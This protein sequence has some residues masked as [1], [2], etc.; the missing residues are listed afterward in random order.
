MLQVFLEYTY[1]P[2]NLSH[3]GHHI[4]KLT[5]VSAIQEGTILS[6][7]GVPSTLTSRAEQS[8][9]QIPSCVQLNFCSVCKEG[10]AVRGDW[11]SGADG[12]K[13]GGWHI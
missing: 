4:R 5:L 12:V 10:G 9:D 11:P 8:A 3:R 13:S 7:V 6:N 1:L 2:N